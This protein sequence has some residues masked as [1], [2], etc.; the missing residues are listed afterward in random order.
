MLI[1]FKRSWT[2]EICSKV[3]HW[4]AIMHRRLLVARSA[5][6]VAWRNW[7]AD[8]LGYRL[9]TKY[10]RILESVLRPWRLIG[11][12]GK[13]A[14]FKLALNDDPTIRSWIRRF[15]WELYVYSSMYKCISLN[16]HDYKALPPITDSKQI[17]TATRLSDRKT[18]KTF[19]T[20]NGQELISLILE[21][22]W[23]D[24]KQN[25]RQAC[26]APADKTC[27][28]CCANLSTILNS[29]QQ[30][31]KLEHWHEICIDLSHKSNSEWQPSKVTL[32]KWQTSFVPFRIKQGDR[33]WTV[34]EREKWTITDHCPKLRCIGSVYSHIIL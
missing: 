2:P 6:L 13:A 27:C 34:I 23:V 11:C 26:W 25:L 21:M 12:T 4:I 31:Q 19:P 17:P 1:L 8:V 29:C 18:D 22:Q 14:T 30:D 16:C 7:R 15:S 32:S 10:W 33:H 9:H 20:F 5:C 24:Q 3:Y 28:T